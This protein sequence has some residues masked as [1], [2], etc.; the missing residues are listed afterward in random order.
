MRTVNQY[1]RVLNRGAAG[2]DPAAFIATWRTSNISAGSS[3]SNQVQ[4]PISVGSIIDFTIDWGDGISENITDPTLLT[5]TYAVAGDYV[6]SIGGTGERLTFAGGGDKLKILNISQWGTV[7]NFNL[8]DVFFGC[9]NLD[10]TATDIPVI[11]TTS[12]RRFFS[13]CTSLIGNSSFAN[14]DVSSVTEMFLTFANADS[15]NQS[16]NGWDVSN[17]ITFNAMFDG[18]LSFNGDI[19]SWD[20]SSA[21]NFANMFRS[22]GAFNRDI[23][24][25]NTISATGMAGMFSFNPVFNQNIGGW[26]VSDVT[27]MS[28]MFRAAT[29][30]NQNLGGW[31]VSKV[32]TF[33]RFMNIKTAANFSAAN[34]DAIYNGWSSRPVLANV[35]ADFGSIKYTASGTAGRNILT[36]APN[37]W[38]IIDGG[39]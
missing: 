32:T 3:A 17:V 28:S 9:S 27:D 26:N 11:T 35:P 23:S 6:V 18:N 24:A 5:H 31:N 2:P 1:Y 10:V 33:F 36:G 37:N 30:F 13:D 12:M 34:L 21:T 20:V 25:W 4:I 19:S 15:F 8:S 29:A 16:L 38:T 7:L 22:T 39:I 14:W